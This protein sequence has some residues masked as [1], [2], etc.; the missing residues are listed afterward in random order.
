MYLENVEKLDAESLLSDDLFIELFDIENEVDFAR[1]KEDLMDRAKVLNIKGR[2]ASILSAFSKQKRRFDKDNRNSITAPVTDNITG[3]THDHEPLRCGCWVAT[4]NGIYTMTMFGPRWACPHPIYPEQILINAETSMCKVKLAYKVRGNWRS[5]IVDKEII[6]SNSKIVALA[7]FGIMVTSENAK[8]L[9]QYLSD[10]ESMN[11]DIIQEQVSTSKLGWIN[12]EFM[13]YGRNVIFDNEQNLKNVF[14]SIQSHGKREKWFDLIKQL[15]K[16]GKL[17]TMIYL[18]ASLGSVLV[19]PIN[20]LPF[21]VNLWGE[22]GKG[23]TVALMLAT[24]VWANPSEGQ[25]L[26]D[27]KATVT[28]LELRLDFLNSLPMMLDDMAQIKNQYD[29]DFSALIYTWCSGKGKDRANRNLGLNRSTSWKNCII[30]NSEHS[31][32]TSTMQG[33]AI[34]RIIDVEMGEGYIYENGNEIVEC[35]KDNYGF[36]GKEFIEV[37]KNVGVERIKE[38]QKEYFKKIVSHSKLKGTEKEEKQIIPMSILLTADHLAEKYIFMDNCRLD[39]DTCC[40]LLKDKGEVSENE[41]A[42][43]FILSEVSININKFVPDDE[44]NYRGECWGLIENGYAIILV[45]AFNRICERG[46]FSSKSFLAW[47]AKKDL[48]KRSGDKNTKTKRFGKSTP[49][50][51]W[52]KLDEDSVNDDWITDT[53]QMNLPFD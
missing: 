42:Y 41:R 32:V 29:G 38:I 18:A 53:S 6:S 24:S 47:A 49:R 50:C 17:E 3:F 19:E 22:T 2:F 9:V 28:A 7:K 15:R 16:I 33:G 23:K 12:E 14:E 36:C 48:I 45:N 31:L 27:P 10:L 46:N 51:V 43:E 30:T 13:P 11:E 37:I 20:A 26:T 4:D 39:L 40:N 5:I 25:Y 34:N 35:I 8:A 52:L 44:D 1:K 21:V